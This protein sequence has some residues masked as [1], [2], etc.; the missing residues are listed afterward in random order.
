MIKSENTK[1]EALGRTSHLLSFDMTQAGQKT[2]RP[3]I[4]LLLS[5]YSL[6]LDRVYRA[7]A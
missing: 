6:P 4:L 5:V 7:V 1:Q 3:T 2:S